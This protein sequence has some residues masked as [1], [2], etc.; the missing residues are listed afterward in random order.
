M[1]D[2]TEDKYRRLQ[3]EIQAAILRD[4]PNPERRGCPDRSII[5]GLAKHPQAIST[6]DDVDE[7]SDWH[8]ITHCSPCYAS[9]LELREALRSRPIDRRQ[10]T[11]RAIIAT[12]LAIGVGG[13]CWFGIR[14]NAERHSIELDLNEDMAF[15]G[16]PENEPQPW[17]TLPTGRLH[18]T[19]KLATGSADGMYRVELRRGSSSESIVT[20]DAKASFGDGS[21]TLTFDLDLHANPGVY[22]LAVRNDHRDVWRYY[23]VSIG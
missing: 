3:S 20:V 10:L 22:T 13:V 21:R 9:F 19:L 17:L 7:R 23:P 5:E 11:R 14:R 8:H 15:R 16:E 1:N 18:L 4:F 6:Q 2:S 12:T